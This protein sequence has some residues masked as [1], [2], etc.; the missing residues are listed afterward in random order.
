MNS[1]L[2]AYQKTQITTTSPGNLVVMLYDGAINFLE[3]SKGKI[4]EKDYAAKGMLIS[5]ALDIISELDC[6]LNVERGGDLARNLHGLYVYCS[7]RLLKAN[8]D[9][10]VAIIDEVITI[11]S[12]LRS[13]F[14]QITTMEKP[15]MSVQAG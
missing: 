5:K 15:A 9:M 3:Q 10:D 14:H 1:A 11:L 8:M 4:A 2:R 6:S 12:E 7:N 13:A